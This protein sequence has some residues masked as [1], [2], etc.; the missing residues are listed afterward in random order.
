MLL[1]T[2][3]KRKVNQLGYNKKTQEYVY[4]HKGVE[5]WREKGDE[6]LLNYF[7]E[8]RANFNFNEEVIKDNPVWQKYCQSCDEFEKK[9]R[10]F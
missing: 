3:G 5:V 6:S 9:E 10:G 4:F 7:N 8:V 1:V 2:E